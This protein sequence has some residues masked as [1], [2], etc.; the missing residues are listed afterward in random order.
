MIGFVL[1]IYVAAA[2]LAGLALLAVANGVWGVIAV[3]SSLF[4][5]LALTAFEYV[6]RYS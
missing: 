1:G 3:F 5:A 2:A 6:R 4:A